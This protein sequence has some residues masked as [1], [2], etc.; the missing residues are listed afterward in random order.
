MRAGPDDKIHSVTQ[1]GAI[2][3]ALE[4]EGVSAFDA[5]KGV[6]LRKRDLSSTT[7]EVSVTQIIRC[8]KNANSLVQDP[9]FAFRTGLRFNA[10]T[11]GL[12]GFALLSSTNFHDA[13]KFAEEY[14]SLVGPIAT[15]AFTTR[16]SRSV[17]RVEPV[18]HSLVDP[19][20]Y[21]FLVELAFGIIKSIIGNMVG[22]RFGASE[23]RV[24][25]A[26]PTRRY[27]YRK[28]FG[29]PVF[30]RRA[31]NEL[32]FESAWLTAVPQY[33]NAV[34]HAKLK[35]L[36]DRLLEEMDLRIGLPGDVRR[37]MMLNRMQG[38]THQAT[39]THLGISQRTLRRKLQ[40]HRTS[41]RKLYDE[42]RMQLAIRYMSE[43]RLALPTIAVLMGFADPS[44]FSRAFRRWT[45]KGPAAYWG[46]GRRSASRS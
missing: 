13:M 35:S 9:G 30:F 24:K 15:I 12:Y 39:A 8:A 45:G 46:S 27:D 33:A 37:F 26:A 34:T 42:L 16:N 29:A 44:S 43:T 1:I 23:F 36:C 7:T 20:L 28:A 2:V 18:P 5:L 17:W 25:Y 31:E 38:V 19:S 22:T 32:V 4:A 21:R 6:G 10:S 11:F 40:E 14:V 41:F 3:D